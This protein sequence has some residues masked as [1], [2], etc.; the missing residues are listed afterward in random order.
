MRKTIFILTLLSFTLTIHSQE[1]KLL[2]KLNKV[3][4][5]DEQVSYILNLPIKNL[6]K[7][8]L[9]KKLDSDL[10]SIASCI[11][12]FVHSKEL[13]LTEKETVDL[14]KRTKI[15][16]TELFKSDNYILLKNSGGDGPIYGVGID[17]IAERKVVIIYLGGD[18]TIDETDLKWEEITSV[19]N[20]KMESLINE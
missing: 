8:T 2:D 10:N 3:K 18:C 15:I 1:N 20:K 17:T 4:G 5:A 9:T 6:E 16:A 14:K 12:P 7:I 13:G 11:N 19:F